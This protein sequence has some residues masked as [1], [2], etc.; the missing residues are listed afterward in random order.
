MREFILSPSLLSSDFG[1][2]RAELDALEEAGLKWVH[3]DVM[4][5]NFVPNITFGPP[6]IGRLRK[7]SKLFFDVHLMIERPE[8]YIREFAD[9]GADLLCIHAEST[10][11][12][13]RTISAIR[14]AGMK[15]GLALNPATPLAIVDY[16]L[17]SLDMVL[18]MSVNP[19]FGGQSFIPFCKD[20]IAA[21]SGMIRSHG[22]STLIQVDGGVTLDNARELFELGADVL[23]SGSAFFGFPPYAQRHKA[24]QDAMRAK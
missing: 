24:F 16:L 14:E 13:E 4:D 2:L 23:V 9:A 17:P 15:T 12:L 5:G 3:W 19:G 11:H 22:L 10:T 8:R 18:I 1:A 7:T 20:K 21:L 6:I